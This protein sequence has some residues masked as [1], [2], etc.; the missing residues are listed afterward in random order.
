MQPFDGMKCSSGEPADRD[1]LYL[2]QLQDM[3]SRLLDTQRE[4]LKANRRAEEAVSAKDDF[5]AKMSHDMR[6]P[7][8]AIMGFSELIQ[9]MLSSGSAD[10]DEIK[11][12]SSHINASAK[13]LLALINDILDFSKIEKGTLVLLSEPFCPAQCVSDVE[14]MIAVSARAKGLDFCCENSLEESLCCLGDRTRLLQVLMNLLNNAV[15]FTP[16]GGNVRF[17]SELTERGQNDVLLR[18][19]VLDSGIGMSPDF[20]KRMFQ[21]FTQEHGSGLASSA[22]AGLG[23]SI[24]KHVVDAMGGSIDVVS[25]P[26]EGTCF[27]VW[28]RFEEAKDPAG[29]PLTED[30][31]VRFDGLSVLICDDNELNR[32]VLKKLLETRGCSVAEA[33][34]GRKAVE[35]FDKSPAG[36]I[37]AVF[38]DIRMPEMDGYE[39]TR[40]LRGLA[41]PDAGS[42]AVFA[43]SAD[44]YETDMQKARESGMDGYLTKP[45]NSHQ[46]FETLQKYVRPVESGLQAAD[47][48]SCH[49]TS[50][51]QS[52]A[53]MPGKDDLNQLNT[54]RGVL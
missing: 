2:A 3:N 12:Y 32:L 41:R 47:Q 39:A 40:C 48:A 54:T 16:S 46:L 33:D 6:T 7:L 5:L 22:G 9:R 36:S 28:L 44:A 11:S 43:M 8:N 27:T 26:G 29:R 4:L 42:A 30:R 10:P 49:L 53:G 18:F 24:T 38:M 25:K 20:Q 19:E 45:I 35:L 31:E 37:K 14:A 21:A 17:V 52:A 15:K 50:G 13:F 1:E 23:L 34:S 51:G